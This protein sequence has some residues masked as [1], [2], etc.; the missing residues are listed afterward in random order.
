M[1]AKPVDINLFIVY[2]HEDI[3]F[4]EELELHLKI[5]KRQGLVNNW[6]VREIPPDQRGDNEAVRELKH[7][8]IILMV[9]SP[10][11]LNSGY[12]TGGEIE[13]ALELH[14][15]LKAD[16]IPLIL[17]ECAWE[18]T[19]LDNLMP[20]PESG[21]PVISSH[22]LSMDEAFVSIDK[23]LKRVIKRRKEKKEAENLMQKTSS[24]GSDDL[25]D[26]L[27]GTTA[28]GKLI[29]IESPNQDVFTKDNKDVPA[30]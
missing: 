21:K 19:S 29:P 28:P 22:W 24:K 16:L 23:A 18:Q 9:L 3:A 17:K 8:D 13:K 11:F 20:L 30:A 26:L 27:S 6:T 10:A 1:T 14:R 12:L 2:S 4:K 5:L 7:P 15:S 25:L